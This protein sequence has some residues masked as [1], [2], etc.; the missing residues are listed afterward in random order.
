MTARRQSQATLWRK[1]VAVIVTA[2]VVI[3]AVALGA[4]NL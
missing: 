1:W 2:L 4:M 3:A